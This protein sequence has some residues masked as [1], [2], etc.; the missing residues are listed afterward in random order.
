MKK[1]IPRILA[2]FLCIMTLSALIGCSPA[3]RKGASKPEEALKRVRFFYPKF[4]DDLDLGTL[5][6]AIRMNMEYLDRLDPE[7]VFHYGPHQYTCRQVR[8]SQEALLKIISENPAPSE[9]NKKIRKHFLVYRAAGRVGNRKTLFTGYFEPVYD[10]SLIPNDTFRYPLYREPDDLIRI[11]L[12]LF[13]DEF[14][15]KS[16]LARIDGNRVVPYF[17]REQIE[18]EKPSKEGA[19]RSRGSRTRSM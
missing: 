15:G 10:G 12:S 8:E 4:Q 3:L 1:M 17:S 19:W 18:A 11:D 9:L 5:A 13:R 14:R 7:R 16:I 2:I 6:H